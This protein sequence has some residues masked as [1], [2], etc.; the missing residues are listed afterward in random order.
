M[1]LMHKDEII[2]TY[3]KIMNKIIDDLM[4]G[5]DEFDIPDTFS[6]LYGRKELLE[7]IL[8]IVPTKES[9]SNDIKINGE[10]YVPET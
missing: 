7:E 10:D 4:L 6:Y 2:E 9:K 1:K 8:G 5:R 3:V